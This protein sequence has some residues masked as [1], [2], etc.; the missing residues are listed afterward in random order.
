MSSTCQCGLLPWKR[1]CRPPQEHAHDE[2]MEG[3]ADATD[4]V[5][6]LLDAAALTLVFA[7]LTARLYRRG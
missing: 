6:V 4:I 2:L 7:P 3:N 1:S 5:V